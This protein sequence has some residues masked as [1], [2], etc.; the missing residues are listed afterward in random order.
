[1]Q[2][3]IVE[4]YRVLFLEVKQLIGKSPIADTEF[5]KETR[6]QLV[7]HR[8]GKNYRDCSRIELESVIADI[9]RMNGKTTHNKAKL[10]PSREQKSAFAYYSISAALEFYEFKDK[11]LALN[12][13]RLEGDAIRQAIY[14]IW[15]TK[16]S[17]YLPPLVYT[18]LHNEWINPKCNK[19]A[20]SKG[21]KTQAREDSFF[22]FSG[23]YPYQASELIK[24]FKKMSA[25]A[26]KRRHGDLYH[27]FEQKQVL[28]N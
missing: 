8:T 3:P 28:T 24:Y 7:K 20:Q 1:M 11:I 17:V 5:I 23:L 13:Q 10:F 27:E 12:G 4:L 19:F 14:K 18:W 6:D 2:A 15:E 21:W 26:Q 25:E 16:K 9:A 22:D